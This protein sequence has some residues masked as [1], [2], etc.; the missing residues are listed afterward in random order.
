ME[1]KISNQR[2]AN[3]NTDAVMHCRRQHVAECRIIKQ[4][5]AIRSTTAVTHCRRQHVVD[6]VQDK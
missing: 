4:R 1:C 5:V 2:V 6:R 3:R